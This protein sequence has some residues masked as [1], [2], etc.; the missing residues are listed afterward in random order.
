MIFLLAALVCT[1]PKMEGC[2]VFCVLEGYDSGYY[3]A[4]KCY[5]VEEYLYSDV[6]LKRKAKT[7]S[8]PSSEEL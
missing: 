1:D 3:K 2:K 7:F 5:C 4:D 8:A 6:L